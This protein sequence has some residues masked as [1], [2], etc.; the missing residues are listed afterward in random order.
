LILRHK[1]RRP[2][3]VTAA[4]QNIRRN[5]KW[6]RGDSTLIFVLATLTGMVQNLIFLTNYGVCVTKGEYGSFHVADTGVRCGSEC[7]KREKY[8]CGL[9]K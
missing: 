7:N 3:K 4:Y 5:T 6:R 1:E 8:R 9:S 2:S